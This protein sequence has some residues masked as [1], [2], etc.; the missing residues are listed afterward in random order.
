[1]SVPVLSW[2]SDAHRGPPAP[3]RRPSSTATTIR[4]QGPCAACAGQASAPEETSARPAPR[5]LGARASFRPRPN[6][7]DPQSQT[8]FRSYGSI[9]P[10]SLTYIV[11][12]A[13]GCSPWRPAADMGTDLGA[14]T[15]LH[16]IFKGQRWR[17][18]RRGK[19]GALQELLPYLRPNRF[20]G[21]RP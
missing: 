9:L 6:G 11:P 12:E 5:S 13:R 2:P 10:T 19:R 14:G 18:G 7:P 17:T 15:L 8:L 16:G 4:Q 20:Q 21:F 3:R 1:M